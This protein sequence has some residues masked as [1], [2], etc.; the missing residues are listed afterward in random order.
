MR[1]QKTMEPT[2]IGEPAIFQ[3]CREKNLSCSSIRNSEKETSM[4]NVVDKRLRT[5]FL[6]HTA[7]TIPIIWPI[8][9]LELCRIN[10]FIRYEIKWHTKNMFRRIS[11]LLYL[12]GALKQRNIVF[13]LKRSKKHSFQL[14]ICMCTEDQE[15]ICVSISGLDFN[16]R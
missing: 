14:N 11:N 3:L 16:L 5:W 15:W 6:A 9:E 13:F 7:L 8:L 10:I 4:T 2:N 1:N 12:S